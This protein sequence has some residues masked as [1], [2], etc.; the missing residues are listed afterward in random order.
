M[1]QLVGML[2]IFGW[3]FGT[4]LV[5]WMVIKTVMGIR[6]TAVEEEEGLDLIDLR[7]EHILNL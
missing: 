4:S 1:G 5:A 2:T 7:M 6:V 3:V